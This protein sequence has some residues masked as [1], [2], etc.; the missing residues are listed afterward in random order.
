MANCADDLTQID[1]DASAAANAHLAS[2]T[3]SSSS[4][5]LFPLIEFTHSHALNID[6]NDPDN[7]LKRVLRPLDSRDAVLDNQEIVGTAH[8]GAGGVWTAGSIETQEGDDE[9]IIHVRFSE[10]VRIKTILI[11]TGGGRL[12]T[13]PRLCR[14]WVNRGPGGTT[15]DEA[16]S[17]SPKSAQEFELLESEGGQRGAVE[18]PVRIARFANCSD[19]DLYFANA[20]GEQSRLYYLGFIGESRVLKKEANEPMTIGAENAAPSLLDGVKEEKRG[21]ATTSAR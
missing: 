9:L 2:T 18:Y 21:G 17:D 20:R 1:Y 14:V 16:A 7:A 11:G 12:A 15:F 13:S 4:N 6:S 8:E 10:L 5:S 19:V 3:S